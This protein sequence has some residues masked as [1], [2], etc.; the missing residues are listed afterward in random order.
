MKL[1][2]REA[3]FNY[4]SSDKEINNP[5]AELIKKDFKTNSIQACVI[6]K[7]LITKNKIE[8]P[9]G[10]AGQDSLFFQELMINA[11]KAYYIN[12]PIHIYYAARNDSVVNT[13]NHKFFEKFLIM[14]RYQVQKLKEYNLLNE[15]INRR[16]EHFM[17]NWYLAKLELIEDDKEKQ[18]SLEIIDEIKKL[19]DKL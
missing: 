9:V 2:D 6:K 16:Y 13:I 7:E 3:T 5:K 18:L 1:S 12:I 8:N 15:Y 4:F 10:A 14:E 11:K 17:N 19:Y